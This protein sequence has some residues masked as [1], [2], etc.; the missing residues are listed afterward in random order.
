MANSPAVPGRPRSRDAAGLPAVTPDGIVAAALELTAHHGLENWTLRQLAG[1]VQAYPA[2]VYHHV[3]DREAVVSAVVD[4]VI[5]MFPLPPEDLLWRDWFRRL[6]TELR[7]VLTRYP[8]V[9]RRISVHGLT[10]WA[11][12]PSIDRGVRIL[13]NAG[14]GDESPEVYLFLSNVIC[15]LISVEDE[16]LSQGNARART[17]AIWSQHR[18]DRTMPGLAALSGYIHAM[19]TDPVRRETYFAD[20]FDY[21]VE[22]CLDGVAARLE[23]SRRK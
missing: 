4:R 2:V 11:A 19:A 8:G 22:R 20:V 10:V 1:A 16:Q 7:T 5:G 3:G 21:S 15:G 23:V 9:A 18:D 17:L 12:A 13:Q 6:A 14:F